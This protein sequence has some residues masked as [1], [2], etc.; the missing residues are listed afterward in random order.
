MDIGSIIKA[1]RLQQSL[2]LDGVAFDTGIDLSHLA[3]IEKGQRTPSLEA[4]ERIA[5]ALGTRVS[6]LF[7]LAEAASPDTPP[8][9]AGEEDMEIRAQYLTLNPDNR[10][11]ARELLRAMNRVQAG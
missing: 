3:R 4:L 10:R 2:T 1:L 8:D 6:T 5:R 9:G 11:M 7:A